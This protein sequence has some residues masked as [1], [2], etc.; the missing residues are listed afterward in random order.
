MFIDA[1]NKTVLPNRLNLRA[2][3]GENFSVVGMLYK[4]DSVKEIITQGDWMEVEPPASAYA[5]IAAQYLK[6]ETPAAP[7]EPPEPSASGFAA[8]PYT[9][10]GTP[11][12]A[13]PR[14]P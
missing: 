10:F 13:P 3:P 14:P 1:T 2:G 9:G 11:S 8:L 12:K 6:L 7:A 4:G 5:F